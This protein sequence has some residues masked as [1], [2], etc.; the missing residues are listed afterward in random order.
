MKT[1]KEQRCPWCGESTLTNCRPD[2][3][4]YGEKRGAS[5]LTIAAFSFF[6]SILLI[7]GALWYAKQERALQKGDLQSISFAARWV[8]M[9][10]GEQ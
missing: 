10:K 9:A 3:V 5:D 8:E 2:C 4:E 7:V 6:V 1:E